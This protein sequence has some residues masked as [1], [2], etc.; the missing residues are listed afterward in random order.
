M[1]R[2][3]GRGERRAQQSESSGHLLNLP[4]LRHWLNMC[5][6]TSLYVL[7]TGDLKNQ[8]ELFIVGDD[9]I[10]SSGDLKVSWGLCRSRGVRSVGRAVRDQKRLSQRI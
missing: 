10:A 7:G 4:Y 8:Q 2:K 9:S 3:L 1:G 5:S 6:M